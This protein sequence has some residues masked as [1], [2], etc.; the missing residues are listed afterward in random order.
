MY[1]NMN[2]PV[3]QAAAIIDHLSQKD[4]REKKSTPDL[5][6]SSKSI[7]AQRLSQDFKDFK[8]DYEPKGNDFS[9]F[10]QQPDIKNL[11]YNDPPEY[12]P[13]P[14]RL[15]RNIRYKTWMPDCLQPNQKH[16]KLTDKEIMELLYRMQITVTPP[17]MPDDTRK[18]MFCQ[19]RLNSL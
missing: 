1:Y 10:F 6:D 9:S 4:Q 2:V 19:G 12:K 8:K 5:Y 3:F 7:I 18:C 15:Y 16:K 13:I 11:K 17:K 14:Q